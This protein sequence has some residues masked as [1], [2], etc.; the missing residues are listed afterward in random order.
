MTSLR[1]AGHSLC[2]IE[3]PQKGYRVLIGAYATKKR[4][5]EMGSLLKETGIDSRVVLR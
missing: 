3:D 4:A 5:D 1:K 2:I